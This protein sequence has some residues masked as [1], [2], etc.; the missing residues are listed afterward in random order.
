MDYNV[1]L[2]FG[3]KKSLRFGSSNSLNRTFLI[4][5]IEDV[6]TLANQTATLSFYAK[7]D[8]PIEFV[9]YF[10]Q[11]FDGSEGVSTPTQKVY[12]TSN[13]QRYELT[14]DIPSVD[15]KTI[16]AN[17]RMN[18]VLTQA[19]ST[20]GINITG[21]KLESGNKAT[22]VGIERYIDVLKDCQRFLF[23]SYTSSV[24]TAFGYVSGYAVSNY[25]L[26]TIIQF[27]VQM[28]AAPNVVIFNNDIANQLRCTTTNVVT[29]IVSP[30][31]TCNNNSIS[32][33]YDAESSP[34]TTGVAYDFDIVANARF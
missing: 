14:F 17:S 10:D 34:F 18:L 20:I 13:W 22:P 31:I 26:T 33:I 28:R 6:R 1:P 25:L 2:G 19:L 23:K 32:Y 24:S 21:A 15:D 5:P 4:H 9:G 27:P 7:A 11:I 30:V 3:F 29:N 8:A 12:L 16:G